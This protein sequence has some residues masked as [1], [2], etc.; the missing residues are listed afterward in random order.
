ME[1][2]LSGIHRSPHR[3][4]S[5]EFAEHK[6][7][8]PGDEIRHIDWK[9]AA[10]SDKYYIKQFEKESNLK[11]YFVIDASESMRYG[12]GART[13]YETAGYLT[14]ALSYLFLVQADAVGL[15]VHGAETQTYVPPRAAFSHLYP[16]CT[17]LEEVEPQGTVGVAAGLERLSEL[18]RRREVAFVLSDLFDDADSVFQLL[19]RL[20]ARRLSVTL[21]HVLDPDE[22]TF[23]F[24]KVT[25]FEGMESAQRVLAEPRMIRDA[26]LQELGRF[27]SETKHR[28]LENDISYQLVDCAVPVE[29]VVNRFLTG[30]GGG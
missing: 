6:E 23:P 27:L 2:R 26:Y 8:T 21:F 12:S 25:R 11:V 24:H 5:I 22:L 13:K 29:V 3:G 14:A 10:K 15:I 28:C 16:L 17:A 20:R 1:G 4:A 9:A 30:R 18:A 19:R 7:Y